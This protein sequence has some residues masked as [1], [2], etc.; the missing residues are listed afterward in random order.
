MLRVSVVIPAFNRC[1]VTRLCLEA[2][3]MQDLAPEEYEV[4]VVDD[5]SSDDTPEVVRN[6]QGRTKCSVIYIRHTVNQ[7]RSAT[8]ND[9]VLRARADVVVMLDNDNIAAPDMLR[10]HLLRHEVAEPEHVTVVGNAQYSASSIHGSNFGRYLQSRYLGSRAHDH[11]IDPENLSPHHLAGLNHSCRRADL[12]AVGLYNT[13]IQ[14][15]GGE[16]ELLGY[17]LRRAGIRIVFAE[18]AHSVHVDDVSISRYKRKILE[19]NGGGFLT[20]TTRIPDFFAGTGVALLQ[21]MRP[22]HDSM[23]VLLAK[24]GIRIVLNPVTTMLLEMWVRAT[25]RVSFLYLPWVCRALVGGWSLA[26]QRS[27]DGRRRLVDYV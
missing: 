10:A 24:V 9:G 4:I 27:I 6:F 12:I 7:G 23:R 19:A 16:D 1:A 25:D 17:Q 21:P 20:L 13:D 5:A 8:R 11:H 3:G 18:A 2:L 14:G 22:R 26:G 15:Y